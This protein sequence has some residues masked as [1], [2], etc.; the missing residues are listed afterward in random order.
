MARPPPRPNQK[1]SGGSPLA[2]AADVADGRSA[3]SPN[4]EGGLTSYL[5]SR[6]ALSGRC[7]LRFSEGISSGFGL[8]IEKG[9]QGSK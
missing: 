8:P 7:P 6:G 5:K 2:E 9:D 3:T 1:S 4:G